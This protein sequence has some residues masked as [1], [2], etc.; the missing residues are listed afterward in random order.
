M[1]LTLWIVRPVTAQSIYFYCACPANRFASGHAFLQLI[2]SK[3]NKQFGNPN[4]CYGFYPATWDI[5]GGPGT[6]KNDSRHAWNWRINYPVNA[7]QYNAV[8]GGI[9]ADR[10]APPA[11]NLLT[12]N[13]VDWIQKMAALSAIALPPT[14][15][16]LGIND[17]FAF[18]ASLVALGAG[19]V[20]GAGTVS[21]NAALVAPNGGKMA[22]RP[23][24]VSYAWLEA[25]AHNI[26]YSLSTLASYMNLQA[27][28]QNLGVITVNTSDTFD[29]DMVNADPSNALISMDW[30]DGSEYDAQTLSFSHTYASAGTYKATLVV[31]DTGTV[32]RWDMTVQVSSGATTG[33]VTIN[34]PTATVAGGTNAGFDNVVMPEYEP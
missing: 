31:V 16:R 34:V 4:L 6:I 2:P 25:K 9:I 23:Y 28:E 10:A 30:G 1:A 14:L 24:D 32:Y 20:F 19:G 27:S 22:Y 18:Q 8:V 12:F 29:V 5:F 26:R 13:C 3:N 17:P 11:Y 21:N 7:A 33:S 15:N